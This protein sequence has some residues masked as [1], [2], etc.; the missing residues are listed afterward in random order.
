MKPMIRRK[1]LLNQMPDFFEK[2]W[3]PL[4]DWSNRLQSNF[5]NTLPA[6]NI[7]ETDHSFVLELAAPGMKKEDFVIEVE[8]DKLLIKNKSE[9]TEEEKSENYTRKEFN[10]QSFK[11]S[12]TLDNQVI[13]QSDIQAEYIDG[14]L[15]VT[16]AKREEAKQ[17]PARMIE[18]S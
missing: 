1:S 17:Q 6:V 3:E 4:F 11:R 7:K 16:L 18:I 13:N 8:N 12:F 2:D 10:Y 15:T 14:V 5:Q 9:K